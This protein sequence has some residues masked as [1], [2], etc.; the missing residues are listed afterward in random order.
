[1]IRY[2]IATLALLFIACQ[3]PVVVKPDFDFTVIKTLSVVPIQDLSSFPGS[4]AIIYRS[5]VHQ[6]MKAGIPVVER[7]NLEALTQEVA[8]TQTTTTATEYDLQLVSPDALLICTITEFTDG[9]VIVVPITTEDKGHTVIITTETQEPVVIE[10]PD[11]ENEIINI[12]TITEEVTNF[13]GTI[14]ITEQLEYID[15][16][17]GLTLQMI[18]KETGDILWSNSYWYNALSLAYTVNQCTAGVV[19]PLKKVLF[20]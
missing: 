13:E 1:M 18:H 6:L 15:A 4:G 3:S 20:Q 7:N 2:S 16:R 14:T 19:K 10:K 9:H 8:I 5:L 11:D 17:I 12:T